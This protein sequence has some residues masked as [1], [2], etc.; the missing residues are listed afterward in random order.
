M[1]LAELTPAGRTHGNT[2]KLGPAKG[3]QPHWSGDGRYVL[4]LDRTAGQPDQLSSFDTRNSTLSRLAL[5]AGYQNWSPLRSG[6]AVSTA[7]QVTRYDGQTRATST[8]TYG[9]G[10]FGGRTP[11]TTIPL[12]DGGVLVQAGATT[13]E[14]SSEIWRMHSTVVESLGGVSTAVPTAT[15]GHV[16]TDP[17]PASYRI[18]QIDPLGQNKTPPLDWALDP[19]GQ[20]LAVLP[21]LT[22]GGC[23]AGPLHNISLISWSDAPVPLPAPLP[24]K[25]HLVSPGYSPE[26]AFGAIA[27]SCGANSSGGDFVELNQ[28]KWSAVRKDVNLAALG[29][30]GLLAAQSGPIGSNSQASGTS[31]TLTIFDRAG[32]SQAKLGPAVALAWGP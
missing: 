6:F 28:G 18:T 2:R 11:R 17:T 5:P 31:S 19:Q 26:G 24:T 25:G 21:I 12:P 22:T 32:Q 7:T 23:L 9:S 29:P 1:Y 13:G 3:S 10:D 4:W 14:G 20:Y 15:G 27:V 30:G 16:P 8:Q